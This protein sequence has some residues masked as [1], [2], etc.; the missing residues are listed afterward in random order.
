VKLIWQ[1]YSCQRISQAR[2][3][4]LDWHGDHPHT[5]YNDL[6]NHLRRKGY[7]IEVLGQPYTC[8][9]ARHYGTLLIV[10]PEE[11]RAGQHN[12]R[13]LRLIPNIVAFRRGPVRTQDFYPEERAKLEHD[14]VQL[15]LSVLVLADWYNAEIMEKIRFFDENTRQWWTPLTGG[16]NVPALNEL[17]APYV[18]RRG[19]WP[20]PQAVLTQQLLALA[21]RP[22]LTPDLASSLATACC[23]ARLSLTCPRP[24]TRGRRISAGAWRFPLAARRSCRYRTARARQSWGFRLTASS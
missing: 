19:T 4:P 16:A 6:Y 10:D 15:G 14:V 5:N 13:G 18:A 12:K 24:A 1:T 2:S 8:F 11:V 7:Y 23:P 20:V 22:S 17:L 3:S 21:L 9:D